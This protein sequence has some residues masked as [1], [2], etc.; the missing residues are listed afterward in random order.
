[1]HM[2]TQRMHMYT[3]MHMCMYRMAEA[4]ADWRLASC[5]TSLR[6]GP[7][8]T[9]MCMYMLCTCRSCML[10]TYTLHVCMCTCM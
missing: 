5:C 7:K 10:Y 1:M 6:S 4:S 3:Y 8:P 2:W 9:C